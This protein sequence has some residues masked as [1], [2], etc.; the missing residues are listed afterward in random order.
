MR[1][2]DRMARLGT[3]TA[4]EVLA[5]AKQLEREGRDIIHLEI[6]EPDFDTP[7]HVIDAA[8]EA[9]NSG[10]THYGPSAGDPELRVIR[11]RNGG[12]VCLDKGPDDPAWHIKWT[13]MPEIE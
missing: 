5:R 3:E 10:W 4:F 7:Q 12:I 13:L 11:F 2:A 9:L 8:C 6:G 1:I